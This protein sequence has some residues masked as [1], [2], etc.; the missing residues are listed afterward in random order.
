MRCLVT[1]GVAFIGSFLVDELVVRGAGEFV[2][3]DKLHRGRWTNL[4]EHEA[5]SLVRF[6]EADILDA[7]AVRKHCKRVDIV[8][9]P[10][11]QSNVLGA[12]A[13]W[14]LPRDKRQ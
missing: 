8:F 13:P 6:V 11:A 10:A 7:A 9:H 4:L 3:V 1:G 2:V 14:I 12:S 5:N